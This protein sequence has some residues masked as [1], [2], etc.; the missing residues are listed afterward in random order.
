MGAS[1][2]WLDLISGMADGEQESE[3][4]NFR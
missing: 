4:G 2:M 1:Q 3:P